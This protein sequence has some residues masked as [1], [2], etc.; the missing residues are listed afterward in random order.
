MDA[1]GEGQKQRNRTIK[2]RNNNDDSIVEK[3]NNWVNAYLD[4]LFFNTLQVIN[5]KNVFLTTESN[6]QNV[7]YYI[8]PDTR[9]LL[10]NKKYNMSIK[11]TDIQINKIGDFILALNK[12]NLKNLMNE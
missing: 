4:I 10:N 11:L 8:Y 3:I 6:L 2:N 12:K 9:T 1:S 7:K 5:I